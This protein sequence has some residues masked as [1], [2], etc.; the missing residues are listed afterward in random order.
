MAVVKVLGVVAILSRVSVPLSDLAYVGIFYTYIVSGTAHL[1]EDGEDGRLGGRHR[2]GA[3]G[4]VRRHT[5]RR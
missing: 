5:E 1:G 4:R 3:A 2:P